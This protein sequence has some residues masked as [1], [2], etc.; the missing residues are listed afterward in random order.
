MRRR[1]WSLCA[2]LLVVTLV[3]SA[4]YAAG[5]ASAGSSLTG[6]SAGSSS[7][8]FTVANY[9][10]DAYAYAASDV[11]GTDENENDGA[12][13]SRSASSSVAGSSAFGQTTQGA[14]NAS[15][16]A[17]PTVGAAGGYGSAYQALLFNVTTAGTITFDASYQMNQ[18]LATLLMGDSAGASTQ[19][20]M[21]LI[22]NNTIIDTDF[23]ELNNF[24]ENGN[25]NSWLTSGALQVSGSFDLG[26]TGVVLI[27]ADAEALAHTIPAPGAL[28]L[29]GIGTVAVGWIR[30]RKAA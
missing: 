7:S 4:G 20:A 16:T 15:A 23:Q 2:S 18:S 17:T 21:R 30:R 8:N 29:A 14:V 10:S 3:S 22:K 25:S 12:F 5:T 28:V 27:Y 6:L 19:V 26:D 9:Y 24:L 11:D 13:Y 1:T